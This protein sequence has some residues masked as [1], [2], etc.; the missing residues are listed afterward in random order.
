MLYAATEA[1]GAFAET[2]ARFRP[3]A[4]MRHFP[5]EDQYMAVG[6]IPAEWRNRRQL[7]E[8]SLDDPLPFLDVDD[9]RTHGF[10]T[11]QMAPLLQG[12]DIGT[13]D[14]PAVRGSNRYL[15]RAIAQWAYAA[16]TED[17]TPLYSGLRYKSKL[18]EYECWAIFEGTQISS[19]VLQAVSK[20]H[21]DL[22]AVARTFGLT[23]H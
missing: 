13:L 3:T 12:L 15:T 4:A 19:A 23:I 21:D 11:S 9:P 10:L 17:G 8:F 7:V 5:A 22:L 14:V 18:G 6:A 1:K 20:T 16:S 2:L